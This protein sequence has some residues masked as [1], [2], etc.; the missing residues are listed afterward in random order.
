MSNHAFYAFKIAV[1]GGLAIGKN[2]FC[3]KNIQAFVFH[4]THVEIAYG[5]NHVHVQV[6]FQAETLFVPFHRI[7]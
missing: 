5:D 7:F 4:R 2:I 6:V 3:I 1:G